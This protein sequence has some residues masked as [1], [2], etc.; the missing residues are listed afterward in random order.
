MRAVR[1]PRARPGAAG[2]LAGPLAAVLAVLAAGVALVQAGL[3]AG[4][5]GPAP[6]WTPPAPLRPDL[7]LEP[8]P[9][10]TPAA[11]SALQILERPLFAANRRPPAPPAAVAEA[12]PPP[13]P[14]DSARVLGLA[15]GA[16]GV[17][18]LAVDGTVRRLRLGEDLG[19]WTLDRIEGREAHF[20]RDAATRSLALVPQ[21]LGAA[22]AAA[23]TATPGP[24]AA[25]ATVV[26]GGLPPQLQDV[27]RRT[28]EELAERIRLREEARQRVLRRLPP[29]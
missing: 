25:G 15:G 11:P 21:P 13:E 8:V 5:L 9:R 1:R 27:A 14:I 29:P 10:A 24:A 22:P 20:R 17:V 28:Q 2:R 12:P 7:G 18:V 4:A 26:P 6:A 16:R 23:A 19:G 3:G